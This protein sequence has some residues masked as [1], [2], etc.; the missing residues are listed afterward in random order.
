MKAALADWESR[1]LGGGGRAVSNI[2]ELW[3]KMDV[4]TLRQMLT[5]EERLCFDMRRDGYTDSEI[6]RRLGG[7]ADRI[8]ID[9]VVFI[10]IREKARKCGF[11]P[12]SERR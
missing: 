5:P 9:Q 8:H 11:F 1:L 10:H 12:P 6:A 4:E 2:Q 3:L 7:K